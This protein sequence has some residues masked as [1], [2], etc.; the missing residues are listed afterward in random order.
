MGAGSTR[1]GR[2]RPPRIRRLRPGA[3][4]FAAYA[5]PRADPAPADNA[6]LEIPEPEPFSED[7]I[8]DV[9]AS[10]ADPIEDFSPMV[11]A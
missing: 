1:Q 10:S 6:T 11:E 7:P 5:A 3:R 9:S 4:H 2:L 8:Q